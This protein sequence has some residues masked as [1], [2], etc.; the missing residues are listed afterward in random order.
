MIQPIY[1]ICIHFHLFE[2]IFSHQNSLNELIFIEK[3]KIIETSEIT[4]KLPLFKE[5]FEFISINQKDS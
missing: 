3:I 4:S 5:S 2:S 1:F